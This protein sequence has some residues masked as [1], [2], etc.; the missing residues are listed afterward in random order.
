MSPT[1]RELSTARH[2][3]R[4][5]VSTEIL[6]QRSDFAVDGLDETQRVDPIAGAHDDEPFRG[7]GKLVQ[8]NVREV[9]SAKNVRGSVGRVGTGI[10]ADDLLRR[11][12]KCGIR[13]RGYDGEVHVPGDEVPVEVLKA[14]Q[15]LEDHL[16]HDV[17][18]WGYGYVDVVAPRPSSVLVEMARAEWGSRGSVSFG[19]VCCQTIGEAVVEEV[20]SVD[21]LERLDR[22]DQVVHI[23]VD[24]LMVGD[25]DCRFL[26]DQLGSVGGLPDYCSG[27]LD[28]AYLW[29]GLE[30]PVDL[31]TAK[32]LDHLELLHPV[33]ERRLGANDREFRLGLIEE[34]TVNLVEIAIEPFSELLKDQR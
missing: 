21:I 29:R 31:G 8:G 16:I 28:G 24:T 17:H 30:V 7:A 19:D 9:D 3:H 10:R 11:H 34:V 6:L 4:V 18:A 22:L 12:T 20:D 5:R 25:P 33:L 26:N 2:A 32:S 23:I 27:T 14:L 13:S 15:I 1:E